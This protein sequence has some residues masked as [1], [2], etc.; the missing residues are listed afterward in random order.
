MIV[1]LGRSRWGF[2]TGLTLLAGM[3]V[4][5]LVLFTSQRS[6]DLRSTGAAAAAEAEDISLAIEEQDQARS[7]A[8]VD[9]SMAEASLQALRENGALPENG[10]E[11]GGSP[12]LGLVHYV[13]CL[14]DSCQLIVDWAGGAGFAAS[15]PVLTMGHGGAEEF[16][17]ELRQ[18]LAADAA[19]MTAAATLISDTV[20]SLADA[21]TLDLI[22]DGWAPELVSAGGDS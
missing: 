6:T 2:A 9:V 4:I 21:E 19:A 17:I 5:A 1:G 16:H 10:A 14:P 12:S 15:E 22:Y 18:V 11:A 3:A 8:L 13:S 20:S 7:S